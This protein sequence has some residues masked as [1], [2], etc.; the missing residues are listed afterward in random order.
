L[1]RNT[2]GDC[3]EVMMRRTA[4]GVARRVYGWTRLRPAQKAAIRSVLR[5]RDTLVVLPTGS[6][7][8]AIYQVAALLIP[9][10]T[11]VVSPLIAL[12]RDQLVG[13][14]KSNAPEAVAIN[15][16]QRAKDRD[17]AWDALRTNN[18][19]FVFLTPE[20]LERADIVERLVALKPSLFVVDEAH[21]VSSWGHD[22]R[23]SYL[24]L[25]AAIEKLGRP[26]ILALTATAAKPVREDIAEYLRMRNPT[27]IITGFDRPNLSL[28]VRRY[29]ED[30]AKRQAVLDEVAGWRGCGLLY[31]ATRKD[32]D[33]YASELTER[34]RRAAAYHGGLKADE[35]QRVHDAF[36]DG[37]L[38]TVVAT[39]AFGMGIDKPDVRYVSHAAITDSLDNYY[40]QIG[41]AGRDGAPATVTLHYRPEDMGLARYFTGKRADP[42]ALVAV[43]SVLNT[44]PVPEIALAEQLN[45]SA[46][47]LASM[48][49]L[50]DEADAIRHTDDGTLEYATDASPEEAAEQAAAIAERRRN[51]DRSRVEMMRQYAE[52]DGC[53]RRFLLGYFGQELPERCGNCDT[54][55]AGTATAPAKKPGRFPVHQLVTHRQWGRGVVVASEPDQVTVLFDEVGYKTLSVAAVTEHKLL[56][57]LSA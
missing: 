2:E 36:L 24:R 54:C 25:G 31:V 53:R 29:V 7:K 55:R 3:R 20:Q 50:L 42:Q 16:T 11:V 57:K 37:G 26:P 18:A 28:N 40:Q 17:A 47:R 39:S 15:S 38:D 27:S 13:L 46:T 22:F 48:L 9:G 1:I 43:A 49:N 45:L 21:C 52:T 8:S 14:L 5:G 51:V 44:G 10:P 19:E 4:G 34:G 30:A 35:R 41:R 23:P 6:G 12:Q 33:R 32:T 56:A